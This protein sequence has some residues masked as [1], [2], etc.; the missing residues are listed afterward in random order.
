MCRVRYW[1]VVVKCIA[2][3]AVIVTSVICIFNTVLKPIL[4]KYSAYTSVECQLE[5]SSE[6]YLYIHIFW[7]F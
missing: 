5:A 2:E 1:N 4:V 3:S 6:K 7:T